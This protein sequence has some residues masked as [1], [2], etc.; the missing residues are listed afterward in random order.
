MHHKLHALPPRGET[1]PQD[2]PAL[3]SHRP[4]VYARAGRPSCAHRLHSAKVYSP[5]SSPRRLL[6][7]RAEGGKLASPC[8]PSTAPLCPSHMASKNRCLERPEQDR[9]L[10]THGRAARPEGTTFPTASSLPISLLQQKPQGGQQLPQRSG[11]CHLA[12]SGMG[13]QPPEAAGGTHRTL[14]LHCTAWRI[15]LPAFFPLLSSEQKVNTRCAI[16]E[17]KRCAPTSPSQPCEGTR[18]PCRLTSTPT[19]A[20]LFEGCG[21]TETKTNG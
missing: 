4:G 18:C 13:N 15:T 11:H 12:G 5:A 10:S 20:S 1:P 3:P 14:V 7:P 9:S 8:L 2:P 16:S 21:Q 17:W 19:A 6:Y